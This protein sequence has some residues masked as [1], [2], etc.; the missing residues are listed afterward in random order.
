MEA[1]KTGLDNDVVRDIVSQIVD[2]VHPLRIIVF[3]SFACGTPGPDSD[4]DVLGLIEDG[5][6]R[7]TVLDAIN[8]DVH[9]RTVPFDVLVATPSIL[10]RHRDNI[11]LIYREILQSGREVYAA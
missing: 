7:Q 10:E 11:G 3:G 9:S 5:G 2:L 4:I 8:R 1:Y 6:E